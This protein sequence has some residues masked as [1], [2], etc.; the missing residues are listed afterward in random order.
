MYS[1]IL[2]QKMG[3]QDI[4]SCTFQ[5]HNARAAKSKEAST[6]P[7]RRAQRDPLALQHKAQCRA[8]QWPPDERAHRTDQPSPDIEFGERL[9]CWKHKRAIRGQ[10]VGETRAG[11]VD[12]QREDEEGRPGVETESDYADRVGHERSLGDEEIDGGG[13]ASGHELWFQVSFTYA[14]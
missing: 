9:A 13:A 10:T 1:K 11:C 4:M 2:L 14:G 3:Y 7:E 6:Q 8:P 5:R 12:A